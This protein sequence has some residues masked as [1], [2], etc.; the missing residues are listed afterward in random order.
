MRGQGR[1][2]RETHSDLAVGLAGGPE[3]L[4]SADLVRGPGLVLPGTGVVGLVGEGRGARGGRGGRGGRLGD[5]GLDGGS[6]PVG[7]DGLGPVL[8]ISRQY[9]DIKRQSA[10]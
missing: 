3:I 9:V 1:K 5:H 6:E 8:S 7:V 10:L 2:Y 4:Q